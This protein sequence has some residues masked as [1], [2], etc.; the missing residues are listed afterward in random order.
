M[1]YPLR[2]PALALVSAFALAVAAC[3]SGG[4]G[5]AAQEQ[6]FGPPGP[7]GG[8]GS[9]DK[10]GDAQLQSLI[11]DVK[12]KFAQ[13]AYEDAETGLTL[14]Y[15]LYTPADAETAGP[16][17]LVFFIADASV[18]GKDVTAPL[19]QG[20]GGLIWASDEEQ[21]K[22][23]AYVLV[24]EFP[25]VVI[26][27]HGA[28]TV[29][30]YQ[31]VARRLV[32]DVAAKVGADKDRLYATGQ[33]MGCMM[34]LLMSANYPD[35]FARELFVS[36]Q[37]DVSKLSALGDQDFFYV[38]AEGD[39][40]ASA[41][42]DELYEALT[43]EGVTIPRATFDAGWSEAEVAE[44]VSALTEK[45]SGPKFVMFKEDTVL[46]EGTSAPGGAGEH[47]YSFDPAYRLTAVRDWLFGG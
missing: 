8:G 44:A 39:P 47:M 17:P 42:Q 35:L 45:T 5:E 33:S 18:V 27:D 38:V 2:S 37:W 14:P 19:E 20:L 10:S 9:I 23:P 11:A 36:G 26:D 22:H 3:S 15:N 40:K 34:L 30:E 43:S 16:L 4:D 21:A 41:G 28:L 46:P 6:S 31:D 24:P 12:P 7:A 1:T 29:N 25:N 13:F 32:L